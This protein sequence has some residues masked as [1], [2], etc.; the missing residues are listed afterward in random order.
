[1]TLDNVASGPGGQRVTIRSFDDIAGY[2]QSMRLATTSMVVRE[3]ANFAGWHTKIDL[4]RVRLNSAEYSASL[5]TRSTVRWPRFFFLTG[6]GRPAR[7]SG[8]DF[9]H[10]TVT[11]MAEH[12][13]VS[14][15]SD[16]H[17]A[18][19]SIEF[20]PALLRRDAPFL[21]DRFATRLE[22]GAT[23]VSSGTAAWNRLMDVR[24]AVLRVGMRDASGFDRGSAA[25]AAADTLI[26][27]VIGSLTNGIEE[28][29]RAAVGRHQLI[30]RRMIDAIESDQ[31][32][33]LTLASLCQ[34][35]NVSVRT[36]HE[37]S[38]KYLDLSPSQYLRMR[39]LRRVHEMLRDAAPDTMTVAAAMARNGLW[40][41]SRAI[42]AYHSMF[43][44]APADTLNKVARAP[45]V[46]NRPEA[47]ARKR[48]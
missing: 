1:M 12:G 5:S 43:G 27:A 40:E 47:L 25:G 22:H 34:V 10:G 24:R 16:K 30:L 7:V 38:T 21:N 17:M 14:M 13:A 48:A 23:F 2:E 4:G 31:R 9:G 39:R 32:A 26:E 28:P 18:W 20:D 44:Q 42:T 36:L 41:I 29:D 35:T 15:V 33:E 6:N 8:R 37:V 19:T 11:Y 45:I 46:E 3:A